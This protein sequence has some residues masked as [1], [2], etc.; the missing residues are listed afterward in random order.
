MLGLGLSLGA[1]TGVYAGAHTYLQTKDQEAARSSA[2]RYGVGG[3]V[4]VAG[5][6]TVANRML[7]NP[8]GTAHGAVGAVRGIPG[9][10][11]RYGSK[12]SSD[13]N[14]G[15]LS[16][17]TKA[18]D[19][20]LATGKMPEGFD[21]GWRAAGSRRIIENRKGLAIGVGAAVGAALGH[22]LDKK[23]PGKGA[24][25]GAVLGGGAALAV[26]T[27]LQAGR[28]WN[29]IGTAGRLGVLGL[30]SALAFGITAAAS[31]PKYAQLDQAQREDS[32][33]RDRMDTIG[34]SGDLVFGLH[35]SR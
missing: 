14:K 7:A 16:Y 6:L 9:A 5:G 32:G 24:E 18:F 23:D 17:V 8:Q 28:V 10:F 27:G 11:S 13:F 12:L 31:R 21:M 22:S 26:S 25:V 33:V 20:T 1:G 34:A 3:A 29:K 4:A 19:E 2:L 15:K 35:N 30:G